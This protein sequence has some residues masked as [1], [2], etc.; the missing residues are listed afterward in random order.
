MPTRRAESSSEY[1]T[2]SPLPSSTPLYS[3]RQSETLST[4]K[5]IWRSFVLFKSMAS[6]RQDDCYGL[7]LLAL[8]ALSTA[9]AAGI[10]IE[11]GG[12]FTPSFFCWTSADS[13]F[14]AL[15]LSSSSTFLT[16]TLGGA[17]PATLIFYYC[18]LSSISLFWQ[19]AFF[20]T[21]LAD[22]CFWPTPE[23]RRKSKVR[24]AGWP[25]PSVKEPWLKAEAGSV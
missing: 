23:P 4:T 13:S 21:A 18:W 19:S 24:T 6:S 1:L 7:R 12:V 17:V 22:G 3:L 10:L 20:S 16:E 14:I 5:R 25:L 9:D 2:V 15:S 8:V 11:T